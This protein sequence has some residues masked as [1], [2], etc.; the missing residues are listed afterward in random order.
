MGYSDTPNGR[1]Y[2]RRFASRVLRMLLA[3]RS[4]R[5][6][7]D[8][9]GSV[10]VIAPHP[11]DESYG[12]GGTIAALVRG[13]KVVNII[14]L[15]DGSASHP[16]HPSLKPMELAQ[17]RKSEA[18]DATGILGVERARIQFLEVPDGTLARLSDIER[19]RVRGALSRRIREL[20]PVAVLLPCRSDGSSEHEAAYGLASEA[21]VESGVNPRLLGF[22]VW[23]L[24]NPILLL[25]PLLACRT[26]WRAG[27]RETLQP[28]IRA[29]EAHSSQTT[30]IPPDLSPAL[31]PGFSS[32]FLNENEFFFEY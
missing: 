29:I 30:P 20:N 7:Q 25:K 21:I 8:A 32:M 17:R 11:D 19:L 27:I 6:P 9:L 26:V 16:N 28:K 18:L 10:L 3:A 13:G 4:K 12:C 2:L 23:S 24:W 5:L 22:P 14:Y 15:T 31:P 1:L